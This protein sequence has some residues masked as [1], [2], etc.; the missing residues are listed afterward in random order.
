MECLVLFSLLLFSGLGSLWSSRFLDRDRRVLAYAL[1]GVVALSLLYAFVLPGIIEALLG[2][3]IVVRVA[4]TIALLAPL[5]LLMGMAYPLGINIL[6]DFGEELVPWA[7]G[8][9]GVMS[10]VA[11]V[12]ATFIASRIGFTGALLTGVAAYCVAGICLAVVS[13]ARPTQTG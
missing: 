6:R 9:N 12:L 13:M 4:A 3:G 2:S 8:M 7:W 11:S 5:G 10:V 1:T